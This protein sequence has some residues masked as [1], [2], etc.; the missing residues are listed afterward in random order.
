MAFSMCS[1]IFSIDFIEIRM[2]LQT[3][4][5]AFHLFLFLSKFSEFQRMP[6]I[7]GTT[8]SHHTLFP[9]LFSL[10]KG[11]ELEVILTSIK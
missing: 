10:C 3:R 7:F 6:L 8:T 11:S 5:L 1:I 2:V 9:I 4:C